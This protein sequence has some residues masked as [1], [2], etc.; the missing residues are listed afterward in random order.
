VALA[1][2]KRWVG[3]SVPQLIDRLAQVGVT[4]TLESEK[5]L[6]EA[7]QYKRN[8][9]RVTD[10]YHELVRA[11]LA[12]VSDQPV[13]MVPWLR[14][15]RPVLYQELAVRLPQKIHWLWESGPLWS[16]SSG[17]SIC[18]SKPTA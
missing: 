2:P 14:Q 12:K 4:V 1:E 15:N 8:E 17:S 5:K 18:G 16:S 11:T 3:W 13:G 10:P 6:D 9:K 7:D